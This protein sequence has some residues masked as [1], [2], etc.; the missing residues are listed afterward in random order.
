MQVVLLLLVC[1]DFEEGE[2]YFSLSET[3]LESIRKEMIP[4]PVGILD[5]R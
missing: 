4:D 3:R 2:L 1:G 5:W